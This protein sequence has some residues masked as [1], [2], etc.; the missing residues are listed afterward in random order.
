MA[1]TEAKDLRAVLVVAGTSLGAPKMVRMELT[2]TLRALTSAERERM[3]LAS[4]SLRG[5]LLASA[6]SLWTASAQDSQAK[7]VVFREIR[8]MTAAVG[9]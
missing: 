1:A 8:A 9:F 7:R 4:V 6:S 5:M 2:P 3:L